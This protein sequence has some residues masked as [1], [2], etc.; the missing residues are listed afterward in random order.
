MFGYA[1]GMKI[2]DLSL[3]AFST[4][5]LLSSIKSFLSTGVG[6]NDVAVSH[7]GRTYSAALAAEKK[8]G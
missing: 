3:C 8:G 4:I 5:S 2:D 1:R 7:A 6:G